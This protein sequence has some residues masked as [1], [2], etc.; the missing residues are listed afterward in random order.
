MSLLE[1]FNAGSEE[2]VNPLRNMGNDFESILEQYKQ[3]EIYLLDLKDAIKD[4]ENTQA[5]RKEKL[6]SIM[7]ERKVTT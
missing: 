3:A 7:D 2:F 6:K 1:A 4:Y 5:E